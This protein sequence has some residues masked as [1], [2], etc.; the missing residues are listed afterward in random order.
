MSP[1]KK[2][3]GIS[4]RVVKNQ[5]YEEYR[6]A[7]SHD[8]INLFNKLNINPV[9]IPNKIQNVESF[10][11]D[12]KVN[13]LILSGGDN[14]GDN[15]IRD[16]TEQQILTYSCKN[17]IPLVGICRGMQ[18]IND[19]FGGKLETLDNESHIK[20]SH[21]ITINQSSS[22]IFKTKKFKV[23]SYHHKKFF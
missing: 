16:Q 23:N 22:S 5:Q 4:L 10:L 21:N 18:A 13:G 19:Y 2:I 14:L 20:Q 9:L 15:T 6:D 17:K 12:M 8:W 1:Q 3:I 7:L 11:N